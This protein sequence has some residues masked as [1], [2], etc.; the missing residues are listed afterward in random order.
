MQHLPH[1]LIKDVELVVGVRKIMPC[2]WHCDGGWRGMDACNRCGTT[3]TV[4][5]LFGR[6][7]PNTERGW[8]AAREVVNAI[9]IA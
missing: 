6:V 9:V 2:P 3:G 8:Q 7:Y 5:R 4:F 1:Q